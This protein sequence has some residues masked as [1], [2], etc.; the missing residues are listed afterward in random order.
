MKR[1]GKISLPLVVAMA[2][3]SPGTVPCQEDAPPPPVRARPM[4]KVR[5]PEDQPE[6]KGRIGVAGAAKDKVVITAGQIPLIE[7]MKCLSDIRGVPVFH[8]SSDPNIPQK[9]ISFVSG[10]DANADLLEQVLAING[11]VC[12]R[13]RGAGGEWIEVSSALQAM[14]QAHRPGPS[15]ASP[16]FLDLEAKPEAEKDIEP[17]KTVTLIAKFR[18]LPA[19]EAMAAVQTLMAP[20]RGGSPDLRIALFP[21]GNGLVIE[22]RYE[23]VAYLRGLLI[24]MDRRT[25][26]SD[27]R[28]EV[29]KLA[30]GK[31]EARAAVI[32]QILKAR[33]AAPAPSKDGPP[34]Q[35]VPSTHAFAHAPTESIVI[36]AGS[37]ED[38]RWIRELIGK[39]DE[40][41]KEGGK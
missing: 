12:R 19:G 5:I 36:D 24:E 2:L 18:R 21:A 33:A 25:E 14:P 31:A 8:N 40:T 13:E 38:L 41:G 28:I 23:D 10:F 16:R 35:P 15:R 11:F 9:V 26:G 20:A 32:E 37:E 6:E 39:L 7:I 17:Q 30:G 1:G 22:T 3:S 27:R 34:P 4:K 29:L